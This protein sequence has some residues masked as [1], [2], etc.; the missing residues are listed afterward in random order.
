M[1]PD[2]GWRTN[3][4]FHHAAGPGFLHGFGCRLDPLLDTSDVPIKLGPCLGQVH[5]PAFAMQK[6]NAQFLF[7]MRDLAAVRRVVDAQLLRRVAKAFQLCNGA[8]ILEFSK[9]HDCPDITK[10]SSIQANLIEHDLSGASGTGFAKAGRTPLDR[11]THPALS[12]Q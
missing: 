4:H 9:V 6:G 1:W 2:G 3:R 7:R 12:G 10:T 5:A 8:E 11:K